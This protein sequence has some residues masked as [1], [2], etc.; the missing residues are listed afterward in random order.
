[1]KK[2]II[3]YGEAF[4]DYIAKNEFNTSFDPFLGGTT[5]NVAVG[6]Q[7]LGAKAYYIC[8]L[9]SDETSDFVR[10]NLLMEGVDQSGCV[11]SVTK[12]VCEV[13]VH[14]SKEGDRHFHS[15]IDYTPH[16][17]VYKHELKEALFEQTAIFYFG[18]GTLFHPISQETTKEAVKLAKKHR[19]L[20]AFDP[21]IRMKRWESE[22]ACR[23]T[24]TPFLYETDILKISQDELLFLMNSTDLTESLEKL[25]AYHIPYV[26][27]TQGENGA[28]AVT[29]MLHVSAK[30][31]QAI[32]TT[33][34][35]DAFMAGILWCIHEK[36]LPESEEACK[37]YTKFAN[38]LGGAV[39][40][41]YGGMI[42][43]KAKDV[44]N[45]KAG[46]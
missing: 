9:G 40:A 27:V 28:V 10:K 17:Q 32:D 25:R 12:K 42:S 6:V 7:K 13:Y 33:G 23:N 16:E 39:S 4:I 31:V 19:M 41:R 24:V 35:G 15:Y 34:A 22:A 8:K 46:S 2:G 14:K 45:I 36:G 30:K 3:S 21:N 37:R 29:A 43:L 1:M 18:S 11:T 26:W 20:V 38:A 44:S 5:V